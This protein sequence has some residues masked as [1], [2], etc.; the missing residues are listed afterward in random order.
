MEVELER[1]SRFRDAIRLLVWAGP[2]EAKAR[3]TGAIRTR[4][5]LA[6]KKRILPSRDANPTRGSDLRLSISRL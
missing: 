1:L 3:W 6:L 2:C 5:Q 4:M